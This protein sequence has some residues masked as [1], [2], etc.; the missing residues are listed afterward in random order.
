[1]SRLAYAICATSFLLLAWTGFLGWSEGRIEGWALWAHTVGAP[2]F[3][4]GLVLTAFLW[5]ERCVLGSSVAADPAQADGV[6]R[7]RRVQRVL[8]WLT[9]L[10][11]LVV[12]ASVHLAMSPFFDTGNQVRLLA[13]HRGGSVALT[14]V[15]AAHLFLALATRMRPTGGKS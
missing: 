13:W 7:P 1:M 4:V 8:F 15:V 9:L 6:P 12:I 10:F 14:F 2:V 3:L 11:G 5:A